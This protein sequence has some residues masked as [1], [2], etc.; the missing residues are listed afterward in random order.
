[1]L[2]IITGKMCSGKDTVVKRLI[3]K[4]FKKVVTYTTRPKRRGETDGVDYHYISKKDFERK[5]QDGFF[6]E[7]RTSKSVSGETWYYGSAKEDMMKIQDNQKKVIILSP[8]GVDKM[9]E[10]KRINDI[11]FKIVYLKCTD[12]TI[13][14]RAKF[15]RDDEQE[16]EKRIVS[17]GNDFCVMD[18]F[19]DKVVWNNLDCELKDVVNEVLDY[20][21]GEK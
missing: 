5:I 20:I 3:N 12:T 9:I 8:S 2:V 1:M 16:V 10:L 4:G 19:A 21:E 11:L 15:R 6:L 7:Y 18:I 13:R 14:E 17:E